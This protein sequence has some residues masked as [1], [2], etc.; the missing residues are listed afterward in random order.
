MYIYIYIYTLTTRSHIVHVVSMEHVPMMV[1]SVWFQSNDV[2]GAQ[3][4]GLECKEMYKYLHIYLHT[5][6]SVVV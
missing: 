5:S 6:M 1:G 4:S 2:S 3:Y